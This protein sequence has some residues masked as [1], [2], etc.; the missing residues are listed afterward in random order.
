MSIGEFSV[1]ICFKVRSL[2]LS[3]LFSDE[4]PL[5]VI[6]SLFQSGWSLNEAVRFVFVRCVTRTRWQFSSSGLCACGLQLVS[7]ISEGADLS[8]WRSSIVLGV[9]GEGACFTRIDSGDLFS[10]ACIPGSLFVCLCYV[11]FCL[12]FTVYRLVAA[13]SSVFC[14]TLWVDIIYL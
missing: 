12:C 7:P 13:L 2:I 14:L 9:P 5:V 3:W 1:E 4:N 8:L 10:G 11:Y 6:V